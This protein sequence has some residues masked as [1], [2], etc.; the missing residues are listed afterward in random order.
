MTQQ[1]TKSSKLKLNVPK[2]KRDITLSF[3]ENRISI[4]K[5]DLLNSH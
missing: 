3:F 5:I 4:T 1:M 2:L